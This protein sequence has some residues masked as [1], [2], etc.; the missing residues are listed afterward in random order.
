MGD[1]RVVV[2]VCVLVSEGVAL[3]CGGAIN[4]AAREKERKRLRYL[5][6]RYG[7]ALWWGPCYVETVW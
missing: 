4:L 1:E 2:C 3:G 7:V 6:V 5:V